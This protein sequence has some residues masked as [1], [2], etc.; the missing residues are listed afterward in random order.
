MCGIK[1]WKCY[2]NLWPVYK[3]PRKFVFCAELFWVHFLLKSNVFYWNQYKKMD[4][5]I[6]HSTYS[7]N[8]FLSHR[9][10]NV[11]FSWTKK[12]KWQATSQYFVK[13]YFYKQV[14]DYHC[15]L[16]VPKREIFDRSD[17]P[18]V[19]T[20]KSSWVGDVVI[21]ILTYYF[22]FWGSYAAFSFRRACWAYASGTDAY[23]QHTHQFLMRMLR[24][25]ISSWCVCSACFKGT[26]LCACISTW[27]VCSA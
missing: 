15:P 27:C 3:K 16:K 17:F 19:Y 1:F 14:L 26:A 21:K 6:P 18:D 25:R 7:K 8:F 9:E 4:F 13:R 20:I 10:I 5:L 2:E 11:Y 12:S 24:E 22:N 23:A